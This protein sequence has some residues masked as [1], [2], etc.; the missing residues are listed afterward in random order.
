MVE[1]KMAKVNI[2]MTLPTTALLVAHLE[3]PITVSHRYFVT[4]FKVTQFCSPEK[5]HQECILHLTTE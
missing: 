5:T 1:F 3:A 2:S 4:I